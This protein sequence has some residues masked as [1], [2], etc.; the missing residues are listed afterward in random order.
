MIENLLK[1]FFVGAAHRRKGESGVRHSVFPER[2]V[3]GGV[4][5]RPAADH[6]RQEEGG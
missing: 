5:R 2:R 6:R 4:P 3:R 1:L